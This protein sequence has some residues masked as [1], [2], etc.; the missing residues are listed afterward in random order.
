MSVAAVQ[1]ELG[2]RRATKELG[3]SLAAA[4]QPGSLV[5]L[6]GPLGSGKTFLVRA[7]CR[8]L[9]LPAT[10]AVTSPTFTLVHEYQASLPIVHADL[11]RLRS[12]REV[13]ELGLDAMRDEGWLV[14][15]EWGEPFLRV[16]G[17][18]ALLVKLSL[19]PRRASLWATG[20]T[21]ASLLARMR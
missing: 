10:T 19:E 4:A 2:N 15:V 14:L 13:R 20:A 18:D 3:R 5:V 7:M 17:G 11:Y 8:A 9:G 6:S 21:G 16:L 12:P 1:I